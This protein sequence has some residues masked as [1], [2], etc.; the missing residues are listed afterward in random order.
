M[1]F[2]E[3][4]EFEKYFCVEKYKIWKDEAFNLKSSAQLITKVTYDDL[5]DQAPEHYITHGFF[6]PR[7]ERMLWGFAFENL[8]KGKI[9]KDLKEQE[10]ISEVPLNKIKSHNLID[11]AMKANISLTDDEVFYLKI[12]QKCAIWAGRYPIPIK[13]E[14]LAKRRE[15][16]FSR[17]NLLK[18]S[19]KVIQKNRRVV[20][21]HDV[22]H[23]NV[24]GKEDRVY[25]NLFDRVYSEL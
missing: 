8:F 7:V 22:M 18:R 21:E 11:L 20:E 19:R 14:Q 24:W 12:A 10:E 4:W 2:D 16:L 23:Q 17:L 1:P 13:K 5:N 6:S 15:P 3:D 9:I 25:S